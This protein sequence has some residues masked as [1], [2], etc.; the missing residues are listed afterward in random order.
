MSHGMAN[1]VSLY[2]GIVIC[3]IFCI[4]NY[5]TWDRKSIF[6]L[7]WKYDLYSFVYPKIS[8]GMADR[9][10]LYLGSLIC[11]LLF[12]VKRCI[13]VKFLFFQF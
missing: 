2:L 8:L 9:A 1:Q 7:T 5:V 11:A 12:Y 10:S 6:H 3:R 13:N 4:S